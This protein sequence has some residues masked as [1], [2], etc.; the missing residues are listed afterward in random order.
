MTMCILQTTTEACAYI[1]NLGLAYMK[2]NSDPIQETNTAIIGSNNG[3]QMMCI[4]HLKYQS[5]T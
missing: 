5:Y 3:E 4:L 1:H 2:P